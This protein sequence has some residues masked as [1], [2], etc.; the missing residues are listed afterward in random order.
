MKIAKV[1][2]AVF[3]LS[4]LS[5]ANE[6]VQAGTKIGPDK[7]ITEVSD[8][9]GFKLSQEALKNFDLKTLKLSSGPFWRIPATAVLSSGEETNLYRLRHGFYKRVDFSLLEC[10]GDFVKVQSKDLQ[11]DDE[12]VI[13]GI[14]FLRIAELAATGD[15]SQEHGH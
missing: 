13:E 5:H 15:A 12:V 8:S 11:K 2:I 10:S 6:D 4:S 1:F 14:G 3:I 7:G 9:E